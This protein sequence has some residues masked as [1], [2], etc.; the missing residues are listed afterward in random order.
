MGRAAGLLALVVTSTVVTPPVSAAPVSGGPSRLAA[1]TAARLATLAPAK[2]AF[3]QTQPAADSSA[4]SDSRSFFRSKTG[5][6]A[7]VLMVVGA[8]YVAY[9]IPKDNEKVHSPIR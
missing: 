4:P 6:A 9:S 5:I 8:G 7:I 2:G 1:S 3:A